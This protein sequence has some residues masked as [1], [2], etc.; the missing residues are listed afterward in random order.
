NRKRK[1]DGSALWAF[2]Q[3]SIL[4]VAATELH[5]VL[6]N[7]QICPCQL[8][9]IAEPREKVRLMDYDDATVHHA[10]GRS[11]ILISR[12]PRE[13][14]QNGLAIPCFRSRPELGRSGNPA[15]RWPQTRGTIC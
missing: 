5:V 12:S 7:E 1:P 2:E 8:V 4:K 11:V 6:C 14:L 10:C 15:D 9:E 13:R 3:C